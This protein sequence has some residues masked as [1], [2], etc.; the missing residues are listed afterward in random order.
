MKPNK[1]T[2][3]HN[4]RWEASRMMLPEHKE[5]IRRQRQELNK[6]T[7]PILDEQELDR[8]AGLLHDALEY[9]IAVKIEIFH[10]YENRWLTGQVEK[11]APGQKQMQI[12]TENSLQ[13]IT[14]DDIL[15]V[16]LQEK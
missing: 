2:P 3:G 8:L 1:L 13:W 10:P 12:I 9:D 15:E 14:M 5:V 11:I 7:K 4:M 16:L 6:K